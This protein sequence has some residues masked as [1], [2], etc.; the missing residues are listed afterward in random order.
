MAID[1]TLI[2][3]LAGL[4]TALT[5]IIGTL[6]K[7]HNFYLK[8]EEQGKE[9]ADIKNEQRIVV[10]GLLATLDG[11]EQLNCNHTVP[12]TKQMIDDYLNEQAH[13]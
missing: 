11:L 12:E 5:V 6:F 3:T 13:K 1:T 4:I 8:Q 9:I 10:K 7:V 2:I